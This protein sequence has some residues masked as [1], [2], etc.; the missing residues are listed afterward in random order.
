M[1]RIVLG[2]VSGLLFGLGVAVLLAQFGVAPPG[3]AT[4]LGLPVLGV[5]LGVLLGRRPADTGGG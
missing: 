5:V 2:I 4:V 1:G 3:N